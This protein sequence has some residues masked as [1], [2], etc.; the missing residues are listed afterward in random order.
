MEVINYQF[1]AE[2]LGTFLLTFSIEFISSFSVGQVMFAQFVILGGFFIAITLT[3]E[4]SG[5]HINPGVSLAVY[6][7]DNVNQ[8]KAAQVYG[9]RAVKVDTFDFNKFV[10]YS[11]AQITGAIVASLLGYYLLRSYVVQLA[12]HP[13]A[14][15]YEALILE[16]ISSALFYLLIL[17]QGYRKSNLYRDKTTS[18]LAI[19]CG[20]ASG[21]AMSGNISGACLNPAIGIGFNLTRF[22]LYGFSTSEI[23]YTWVYIIGPLIGS[24]LAVLFFNSVIKNYFDSNASYEANDEKNDRLLHDRHIELA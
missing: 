3:R 19:T 10:I 7:N 14:Y 11:L 8:T 17:T 12:P 22:F 6:L 18:T 5:G 24:V 9:Q 1:F 21:I 16:A 4:I 23:S 20:L 15:S 13:N 2:M